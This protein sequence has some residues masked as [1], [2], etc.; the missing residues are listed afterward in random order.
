MAS[1]SAQL[2][3]QCKMIDQLNDYINN[4]CS[5]QSVQQAEQLNLNLKTEKELLNIRNKEIQ[6]QTDELQQQYDHLLDQNLKIEETAQK[7]T[8]DH[9]RA[10]VQI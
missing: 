4:K 2:Q 9:G 7:M 6:D 8:R 10:M 1:F 5:L 3:E